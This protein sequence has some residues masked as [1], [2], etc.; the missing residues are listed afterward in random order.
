MND[1]I[2][3]IQLG[4]LFPDTDAFKN[5]TAGRVYSIEGLAPTI[6]T[7]TGG[8]IIPQIVVYETER[9]LRTIKE[10]GQAR[11]CRETQP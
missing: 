4:N 1:D 7:P 6:R 3:I 11:E 5:R 9:D 10:Q 2:T 8:G